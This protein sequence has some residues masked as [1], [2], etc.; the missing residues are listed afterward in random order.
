MTR[1]LCH[2]SHKSPRLGAGGAGVQAQ[3]YMNIPSSPN[4][5][6]ICGYWE[7]RQG[8]QV[9]PAPAPCCP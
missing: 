8:F 6:D 4:Q 7:T 2:L 1:R 5:G 9:P 3:I